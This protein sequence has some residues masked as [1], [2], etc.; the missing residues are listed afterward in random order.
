MEVRLQEALEFP[1][2]YKKLLVGGR[3]MKKFLV[4]LV[5]LGLLSTLFVGYDSIALSQKKYNEAPMLAEL[6]KQG[7]LPP[8]EQRLPGKPLILRPV[9]QVG[10]YG[11]TFRGAYLGLS[12]A[13]VIERWRLARILEFSPDGSRITPGLAEKWEISKDSKEFTFYL[14]KG[15]KW[16]DGHPF[17][18]DDVMFWYSSIL[19]NKELT[20][21]F[22]SWLTS[23]PGQNAKIEKINEFTFKVIFPQPNA[24]FLEQIPVYGGQFA[25]PAHYLRQFH[26]SY[27]PIEKLESMAKEAKFE[28]WYQLFS[29]KAASF[30]NPECPVLGAYRV[31]TPPPSPIVVL[32][33]NPYY[34]KVD[35]K[36]NQLPYI[37]KLQFEFLE[38]IDVLTMK[39]IAGEYDGD[40][41]HM[42]TSDYS[43]LVENSKKGDYRVLN[44]RYGYGS[45]VAYYLNQN[46]KDPVLKSLF[47]NKKFRTALSLAINRDDINKLFYFGLAKPRQ[48][49]LVKGSPYYNPAWEKAYIEY[50]PKEANR[51]LDEIGLSKRDKDGIRLRPDGKPLT[52]TIEVMTQIKEWIDVTEVVKKY[53]EDL[54]IKILMKSG[55][56]SLVVLHYQNA[57]FEIGVWNFDRSINPLADPGII[58]GTAM[59]HPWAPL[60]G[61]WYTSGGKAGEEP[62]KEVKQI[63]ELWEKVR[64][65]TDLKERDR[66][67]KDI[68]R[69]H[70][71]NIWYIGTVG[72]HPRLAVVKNNLRNVPEDLLCE[73]I[74]QH[75][76]NAYPEQFY[77]KR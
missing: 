25:A 71:N 67:F 46:V 26:P 31:V 68:V 49:S 37:D 11:G 52:L 73:T 21:Q 13:Y 2:D 74:L 9:E 38:N 50:N 65:A 32:E 36:G 34:W 22:P 16:S 30:Q 17:T 47:H 35:V 6:V 66:L 14:R 33:R 10:E 15:L 3:S 56:R 5:M 55:E 77:F 53:W 28:K 42:A 61:Q 60:Y 76:S 48:A 62:T 7:K 54:G 12:D 64:S 72:E 57:D 51:L 58:L 63:Y 19:L 75:P 41:L 1:R 29:L 20:P 24:I 27:T 69:I 44:W 59:D 8:V 4:G 23:G 18:T 45:A 70:Y 43:L 39:V 40:F